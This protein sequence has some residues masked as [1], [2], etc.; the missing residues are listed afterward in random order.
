MAIL[1]LHERV[2]AVGAR[3]LAAGHHPLVDALALLVLAEVVVR[4]RQI[5]RGLGVARVQAQGF[6]EQRQG[7]EQSPL[8][9]VDRAQH[10]IDVRIRNPVASQRR[11]RFLRLVVLAGVEVFPPAL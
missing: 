8:V 3:L 9:I 7:V 11:E 10:R 5:Q 6:V 4:Q 1:P 2:D